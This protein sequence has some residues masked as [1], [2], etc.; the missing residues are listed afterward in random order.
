MY[1]PSRDEGSTGCLRL[2]SD[3]LCGI[4]VGG[5]GGGGGPSDSRASG[6]LVPDI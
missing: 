1:G 6:N 5:G 4:G 3:M 2:S